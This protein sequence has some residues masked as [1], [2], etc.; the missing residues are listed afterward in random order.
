MNGYVIVAYEPDDDA[1]PHLSRLCLK[2]PVDGQH[3]A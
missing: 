2:Y 1:D 3:A